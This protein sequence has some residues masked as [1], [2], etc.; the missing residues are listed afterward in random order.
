MGKRRKKGRKHGISGRTWK[1]KDAPPMPVSYNLTATPPTLTG[2]PAARV[3]DPS[4]FLT[5]VNPDIGTRNG[6]R[7]ALVRCGCGCKMEIEARIDNLRAGTVSCPTRRKE[8]NR[9]IMVGRGNIEKMKII[10]R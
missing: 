4:G 7:Y 6:H 1:R 9:R 3:V 2:I 5:V 8:H 10:G